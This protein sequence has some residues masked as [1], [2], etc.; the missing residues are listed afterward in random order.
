M[1]PPLPPWS[2]SVPA[3]L[4]EEEL[5]PR[6][7]QRPAVPRK[8]QTLS[9][10]SPT[11]APD[12]IQSPLSIL[13]YHGRSASSLIAVPTSTQPQSIALWPVDSD[14]TQYSLAS[15]SSM[16]SP[17]L[18]TSSSSNL[19]SGSSP[20]T[21]TSSAG[22]ALPPIRK[23]GEALSYEIEEHPETMSFAQEKKRIQGFYASNA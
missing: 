12:K 1:P 21:P 6:S 19:S 13:A 4:V 9:P 17:G 8:S 5:P 22:N 16:P 14:R 15:A 7:H 23:A 18:G 2:I 20:R 3:T 11:L 10:S